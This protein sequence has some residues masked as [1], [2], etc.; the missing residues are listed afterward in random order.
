MKD[1]SDECAIGMKEEDT[2]GSAGKDK[3]TMHLIYPKAECRFVREG[4]VSHYERSMH[5]CC[6][7]RRWGGMGYCG[8]ILL[9]VN[10]R[11]A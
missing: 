3:D 6:S 11:L 8:R 9:F 4:P 1:T 2:V 10:S 5:I 7:V